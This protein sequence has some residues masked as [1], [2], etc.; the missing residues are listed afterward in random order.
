MMAALYIDLSLGPYPK[1]AGLD[2]WGWSSKDGAQQSLLFRDRDA[3]LYSGPYPV[4]AHPPCGPWGRFS[5]NYKGGEGSRNCAI[6]AVEQVRSFGG[7]LEHPANSKLWIDQTLPEPNTDPDR[8]G[9]Y[10]VRVN[11]C[12]WGHPAV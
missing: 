12:D 6:R 7:V 3:T 8:F 1:I 11:Q 5:W 9:G 2:C 4:I 10:T